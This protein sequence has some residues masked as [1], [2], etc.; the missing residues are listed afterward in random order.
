MKKYRTKIVANSFYN[1]DT[2]CYYVFGTIETEII[3][4]NKFLGP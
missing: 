3:P 4:E 1:F 2:V